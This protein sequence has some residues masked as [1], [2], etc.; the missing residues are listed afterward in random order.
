MY[1]SSFHTIPILKSAYAMPQTIVKNFLRGDRYFPQG[2]RRETACYGTF[3]RLYAC[4]I[5]DSGLAVGN[6]AGPGRLTLGAFFEAG[7]GNYNSYNSFSQ[8]SSVNGKGNMDYYG[9]GILGRYDLTQGLLSG[10]YVDASARMG[11]SRTEFR[12]DDIQYNGW[13]SNFESAA[14]Y[15]GLHGGLGYIWKIPGLDDKASL[16]LS[17]KILWTRQ[18]GDSVTVYQDHLRFKDADSLR[19]RLGGRFAYAVNDYIAPYIGAY[20]EHEFDG[21][22]RATVNGVSL[23]APSLK[24]DTGMGELGLSLKPSKDL[25]LTFDLGVQGYAG[26]REGVTGSLQ[27]RFEF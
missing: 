23:A 19:T 27:I 26:K 11:G 17:A 1:T 2:F 13:H 4:S 7:W 20:W 6:D 9:G 21:K 18:Q 22:A 10:L 5:Q 8:S 14:P 3:Y 12:S 24:G 16:D 15:Y 25:P